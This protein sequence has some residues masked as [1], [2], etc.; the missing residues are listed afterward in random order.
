MRITAIILAAGKGTR[1]ADPKVNKTAYKINGKSML[2]GGLDVVASLVDDTIVVVGYRKQSVID[3]VKTKRIKFVTQNKR[4]G[5]GH[6]VKLALKEIEKGNTKPDHIFVA[7]GDHLFQVS[8]KA[9]RGLFKMHIA[10]GNDATVLTSFHPNPVERDNGR[11]IRKNGRIVEIV[12]KCDFTP[13]IRKIDELNSGNYIFRYASLKRVLPKA[14]IVPGKE[15]NIVYS[16]FEMG[17]VGGCVVS[18]EDVGSGINSKS[19][20]EEY[21]AERKA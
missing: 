21:L 3:T 17:K 5:T 11:I 14:S 8:K 16:I 13:E 15:F 2:Q 12:E 20:L 1:F 4:L 7:N 18:F 19:D 10:E 9:I 6:A